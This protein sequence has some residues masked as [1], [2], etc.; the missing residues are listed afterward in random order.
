MLAPDDDVFGAC[1][2]VGLGTRLRRVRAF[3]ALA[4]AFVVGCGSEEPAPIDS[5]P[6][7]TPHLT[8]ANPPS[9]EGPQCISVGPDADG[10]VPLLVDVDE[11]VLRPPGGCGAFVQCGHLEIFVEGKFNNEGAVPAID[12]LLRK[13]ADPF[14]DGSVDEAT[15][16]PDLLDVVAIVVDEGGL[17]LR[18]EEGQLVTD[19]VQLVTVPDCDALE[20]SG[21]D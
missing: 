7:G 6:T 17:W 8:F 18:D 19:S 2:G 1:Y 12:L 10:Q 20:E 5:G 16:E 9:G 14:H 15:G 13:L 21:E 4:L 11:L 3:V